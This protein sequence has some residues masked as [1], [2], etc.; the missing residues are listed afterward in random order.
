MPQLATPAVDFAFDFAKY[1]ALGNDYV[2]IDPERTAFEPTPERVRLVCDRHFGLGADGVL[3]GPLPAEDGSDSGFRLEIYNSDGTPCE[4]SGNG[5]RIFAQYLRDQGRTQDEEFVLHSAGGPSTVRIVDAAA[6]TVRVDLGRADLDSAAVGAGGPRRE[7]LREPLEA[8]GSSWTATCL[9]LGNPHCV[10]PLTKDQVT[11][12][13]AR[14]LG[15]ALRDHRLF[16][17]RINVQLMEVLDRST[18]RIE[19]FERGAGY[20]LAS[21][22][23]GCA[24]AVA[25]HALG[26]TG[27]EVTVRMPGGTVRVEIAP[28]GRVALTGEIRPVLHGSW[29]EPLRRRL[30]G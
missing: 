11:E 5:L 27:P 8:L 30:T 19:I 10:I 21:G 3:F 6:G 9:H 16:P 18:I 4:K 23:S 14:R 22:S 13:L 20:T 12:E 15:P 26:L 25:A 29:A 28:D 17:Q 7:L 2:V 24:A 1:Q